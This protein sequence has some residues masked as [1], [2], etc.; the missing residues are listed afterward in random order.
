VAQRLPSLEMALV[1]ARLDAS[2]PDRIDR[3]HLSP[4]RPIDDVRGSAAYRSE[5]VAT[6]LRRLLGGL[7]P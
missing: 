6:L 7:V 2:L 5:A 4:L 1:G 3:R